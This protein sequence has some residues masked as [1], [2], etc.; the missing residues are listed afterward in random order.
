MVDPSAIKTLAQSAAIA[1]RLAAVLAEPAFGVHG[2]HGP[3]PR[4]GDGLPVDPVRR[5]A[6][7]KDAGHLCQE[8]G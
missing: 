5:V 2:D 4:R 1:R 8:G 6:R 7:R 3:G